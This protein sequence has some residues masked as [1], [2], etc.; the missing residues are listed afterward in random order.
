[1]VCMPP[2]DASWAVLPPLACSYYACGGTPRGGLRC[3]P[4]QMDQEVR[5]HVPLQK[6]QNEQSGQVMR[7]QVNASNSAERHEEGE[8]HRDQM[9]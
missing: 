7:S 4:I 2:T 9:I 1:M 5:I 3:A 6:P 8:D